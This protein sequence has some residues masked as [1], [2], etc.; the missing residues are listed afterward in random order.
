MMK[1]LIDARI[2]LLSQRAN[3]RMNYAEEAHYGHYKEMVKQLLRTTDKRIAALRGDFNTALQCQTHELMAEALEAGEMSV[4]WRLARRSTANN[5]GPKN[6]RYTR[7]KGCTPSM[8]QWKDKLQRPGTD[9]G[10]SAFQVA[11]ADIQREEDDPLPMQPTELHI[12]RAC[13]LLRDLKYKL[14]SAPMR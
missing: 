1:F 10:C 7:V 11:L 14:R 9:G 5:L 4:V 12:T 13:T 6:R 3:I 2:A 8:A